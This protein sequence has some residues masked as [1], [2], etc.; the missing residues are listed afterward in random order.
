[1]Y[2][3]DNHTNYNKE[4]YYN[5]QEQV[6]HQEH[7]LEK[8]SDKINVYVNFFCTGEH[9]QGEKEHMLKEYVKVKIEL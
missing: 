2:S 5:P 4:Q 8:E 7:I 1:M 6:E 3:I 9:I